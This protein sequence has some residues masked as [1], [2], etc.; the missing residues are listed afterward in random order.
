MMGLMEGVRTDHLLIHDYS[1]T[2]NNEQIATKVLVQISYGGLLVK[3][4]T[5]YTFLCNWANFQSCKLQL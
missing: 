3:N 2:K 5:Y 1:L 4:L